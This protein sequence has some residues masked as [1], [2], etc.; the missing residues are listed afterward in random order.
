[1]KHIMYVQIL[2]HEYPVEA[3]T[4][5]ELYVHRLA[6]FVQ[7]KMQEL[8]NESKII[9]SYKLAVLT[10]MNIADELFRM[11]E[12]KGTS[13][14]ADEEKAEEMIQLLDNLL[15][16]KARKPQPAAVL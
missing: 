8:K 5:D 14:K 13:S 4:G 15:G 3:N 2:G 11:Q 9:D 12:Q 7:E 6:Q 1:M 10:A 16:E